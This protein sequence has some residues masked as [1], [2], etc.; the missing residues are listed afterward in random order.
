MDS[1][2]SSTGKCWT[3]PFVIFRVS[4]LFC[5][6]YSTVFLLANNEDPDQMPH[7]VASD[8]G[9]HCLSRPFQGFHVKNE[10]RYYLPEV[11]YCVREWSLGGDVGRVTWIMVRLKC[12]KFN[13]R[14]HVS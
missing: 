1:L 10:L 12:I 7:Y 9:L 13:V 11:S 8:L 3:S 5:H 6:F 14:K 4:G 2:D